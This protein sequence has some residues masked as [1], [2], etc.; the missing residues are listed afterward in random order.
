MILAVIAVFAVGGYF[1]FNFDKGQTAAAKAR[2]VFTAL[3]QSE[4]GAQAEA[5][6]KEIKSLNPSD[7]ISNDKWLKK[8]GV[9]NADE[10]HEYIQ[11]AYWKEGMLAVKEL[12]ALQSNPAK[13]MEL[14]TKIFTAQAK[15]NEPI[16]NFGTS[17]IEVNQRVML[18]KLRDAARDGSLTMKNL[19]STGILVR[20]KVVMKLPA[21]FNTK[22][23]KKK[24]TK[25]DK[26]K[27][28][29]IKK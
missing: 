11:K 23:A 6:A 12:Q 22:E 18:N 24:A 28:A 19:E 4:D 21:N 25:T 13:A 17:N 15:S 10:I 8:V 20:E 7:K 16:G 29:S 3:R 1:G 14:R 9:A 26:V 5:F 27:V 2:S